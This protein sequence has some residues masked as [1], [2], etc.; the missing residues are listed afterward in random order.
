MELV[1]SSHESRGVEETSEVGQD[2]LCVVL[3][4]MMMMITII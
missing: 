4:I 1:G 3:P 2:S